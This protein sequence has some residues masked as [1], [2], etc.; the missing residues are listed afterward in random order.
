VTGKNGKGRV[1][2]TEGTGATF[3]SAPRCARPREKYPAK[4]FGMRLEI[5][6]VDAPNLIERERGKH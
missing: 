3:S 2:L 6:V 1:Y 5:N 4:Y